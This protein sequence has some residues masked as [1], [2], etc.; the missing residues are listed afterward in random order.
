MIL[1]LTVASPANTNVYYLI[2]MPTSK[3]FQDWALGE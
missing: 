2:N 1:H 3:G